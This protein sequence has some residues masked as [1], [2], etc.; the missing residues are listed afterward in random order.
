[1]D[2]LISLDKARVEGNPW[3]S[4]PGTVFEKDVRDWAIGH[5][6]VE[7]N[8]IDGED[9]VYRITEAGTMAMIRGN[10]MEQTR[11]LKP[12]KSSME[13]LLSRVAEAPNHSDNWLSSQLINLDTVPYAI[14]QEAQNK[15]YIEGRGKDRK[16]V[17]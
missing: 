5:Q 13:Y 6:L 12:L 16:S 3:T 7:A 1:M 2:L 17:V 9:T 15:G 14:R 10:T 8:T 11:P 4:T